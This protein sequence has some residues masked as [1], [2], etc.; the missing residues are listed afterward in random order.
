MRFQTNQVFAHKAG[1]KLILNVVQYFELDIETTFCYFGS[2]LL[3]RYFLREELRVLVLVA[4]SNP[5]V[6]LA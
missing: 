1:V 5:L 3:K 6:K 2:Q 4:Q